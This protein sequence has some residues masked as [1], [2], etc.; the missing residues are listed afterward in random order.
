MSILLLLSWSSYLNLKALCTLFELSETSL[1]FLGELIIWQLFQKQHP[2][3]Y[4]ICKFD[5]LSVTPNWIPLAVWK[6]ENSSQGDGD[7]NEWKKEKL[8]RWPTYHFQTKTSFLGNSNQDFL[9]CDW[10]F[11]FEIASGW[12]FLTIILLV[13]TLKIL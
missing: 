6:K 8:V 9:F 12:I 11:Y 7:G 3:Q 4:I 2:F 10:S 1:I 5:S 13:G